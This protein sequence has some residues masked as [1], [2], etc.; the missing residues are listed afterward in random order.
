MEE[1]QQLMKAGNKC[2]QRKQ[3][4]QAISYYHQSITL[5][6]DD[7][8]LQSPN[9]QQGIQGWICGYHN[10]ASTYEQQGLIQHSRK[11]L[12][13]PLASM[14]K[15]SH[16]ET[17]CFEG[18]MMAHRVL[19]LTLGPLCTFANKYPSEYAAINTF[20]KSI[21]HPPLLH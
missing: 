2:Y 3:W 13:R 11:A 21:N 5:L 7:Y 14:I 4:S 15:R 17:T 16:D 18:Q 20:L 6:E 9:L 12:I 19:H 8:Y 1:W 10:L